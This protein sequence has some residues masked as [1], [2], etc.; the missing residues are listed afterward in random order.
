MKNKDVIAAIL[1]YHPDLPGYDGCDDYKCG[2]PEAECT[3]VVSAMVASVGV[4]REAAR[5]GCNLIIVH[6]PT[7]Y[8][9]PDFPDWR[10]GFE[11]RIYQ[12]KLDLLNSH[13]ITIWR[14]HDHMHTHEPDTIFSGVIR[15]LGWEPYLQPGEPADMMFKF[16][17]PPT[18]VRDVESQL[19]AKLG[20]NGARR[21][22]DPDAVVQQVAIVGHLF[23]D[24]HGG[25][26]MRPDGTYHE[27]ATAVM[28]A[29]ESGVELIIPGEVV[30]WTVLSYIRDAVQLGHTKAML[31]LGHFSMEELGM[32]TFA[33]TLRTLLPSTVPVHYVPSG[34]IY[35]Y[36]LARK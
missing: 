36:S 32:K 8:T 17:L 2:D 31:S 30:E 20:L 33:D 6:E 21:I 35:D 15:E 3:G 7:F 24:A 10:G 22:G 16:A 9:T 1:A 19:V 18:T 27:Y 4:V 26:G 23:P 25:S 14:N 12:E 5:L 28:R 34:D 29:M 11:N 13:G